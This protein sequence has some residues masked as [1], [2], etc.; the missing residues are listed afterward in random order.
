MAGGNAK[1]V[2]DAHILPRHLSSNYTRMGPSYAEQNTKLLN[3]ILCGLKFKAMSKTIQLAQNVGVDAAKIP[4]ALRG[5]RTDCA[6]LQ[7]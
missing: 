4:Q 5:G 1:H 7:E 3:Q 2:A 6:T